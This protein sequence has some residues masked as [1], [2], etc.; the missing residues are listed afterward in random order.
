M[1][2]ALEEAGFT[3]G[4]LGGDD[5]YQ[6]GVS[7]AAW[8][9]EAQS[10]LVSGK[11]AIIANGEV[12]AADLVGDGCFGKDR[13]GLARAR[14][15]FD[16]FSAAP[17][18]ARQCAPLVLTDP[19][20]VPASTSAFLD[21]IRRA[22]DD[23]NVTLT[24]VGGNAA[25][26]Q[27]A[28]DAYLDLEA[29]E[30]EDDEGVDAAEATLSC[31][32]AAEVLGDRAQRH[33][34]LG[35]VRGHG[36]PVV[37]DRRQDGDLVGIGELAA[38]EAVLDEADEVLGFEG[39]EEHRLGLGRGLLGRQQGVDRVAARG[40]VL[41]VPAAGGSGRSA[42]GRFSPQRGQLDRLLDHRGR[43]PGVLG[44]QLGH[45]GIGGAVA[46]SRL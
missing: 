28:L 24:V 44:S 39:V 6:T 46:T 25:V 9:T 4:R 19:K 37:G 21:D 8:M 5:R 14:V 2:T 33:E 31:G 16:S 11:I 34:R 42:P 17:L 30:G 45:L 38:V 1:L 35:W 12:F 43:Q 27:A 29:E 36:R 7:V 10:Q 15:P 22:V 41:E 26:S 18:M 40:A 13:V 23:G 32:G 20:N 3:V